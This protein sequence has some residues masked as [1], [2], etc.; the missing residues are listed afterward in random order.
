M[1]KINDRT[2]NLDLVTG[3]CFDPE[4]SCLRVEWITGKS[5]VFKGAEAIA[6]NKYLTEISHSIMVFKGAEAIDLN[7][8]LTEISHSIMISQKAEDPNDYV[9]GSFFRGTGDDL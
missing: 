4:G 5:T 8:Y 7:K 6:L 1:I 2:I 9:S 3:T